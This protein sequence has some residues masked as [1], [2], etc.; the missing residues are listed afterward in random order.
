MKNDLQFDY[1]FIMMTLHE[2]LSS[3]MISDIPN[4]YSN[5]SLNNVHKIIYYVTNFF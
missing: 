4:F 2:S 1:C 3:R 5:Y